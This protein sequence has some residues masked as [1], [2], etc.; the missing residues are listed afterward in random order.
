MSLT[1]FQQ[2]ITNALALAGTDWNQGSIALTTAFTDILQAYDNIRQQI[3]MLQAQ[4]AAIATATASRAKITKLLTD[5]G[6]F[7]GSMAKFE[8]WWAKVKA[9][10]FKNHLAITTNTD[11]PVHTVLSCLQGTK[12]VML[13]PISPLLLFAISGN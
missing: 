1:Q 7:N 12:V 3:T 10:Q 11:K 2:N 13:T 6:Q 9:W 4:A 5:P 8:E